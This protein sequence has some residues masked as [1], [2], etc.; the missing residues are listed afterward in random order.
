M[1]CTE[2]RLNYKL[3]SSICYVAVCIGSHQSEASCPPAFVVI[4]QQL[5]ASHA[6][7]TSLKSEPFELV[8]SK[9]NALAE[10]YTEKLNAEARSIKTWMRSEFQQIKAEHVP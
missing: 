3:M 7:M 4:V 2:T 10:G 8:I 6:G 5:L 9:L 1:Y